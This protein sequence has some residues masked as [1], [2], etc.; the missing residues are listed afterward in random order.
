MQEMV[1][2]KA[3]LANDELK[4]KLEKKGVEDQQMS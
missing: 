2:E 1:Q 4:L 3:R